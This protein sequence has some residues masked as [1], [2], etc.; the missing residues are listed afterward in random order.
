MSI[1]W[2]Q[3]LKQIW[4][5]EATLTR[6]GGEYD[7]NFLAETGTSNYI[8][9]VMRTGCEADFIDLQ[10]RAFEHIRRTTD[11]VPVPKIIKTD[12]GA[13]YVHADDD[14]GESRII[15]LMEKV[16]GT[17]YGDWKPHSA[18]LL[19]NIGNSVG[20]L[21]K[22][23]NS[24]NHPALQRDFK[25]NL[26][27]G[28]WIEEHI[29][30]IEG[31]N[32]RHLIANV[33]K[34]FRAIK[35]VLDILPDVAIHNDVND[36]NII[37]DGSL[38]DAAHVTGIIDLGD[39]C[40]APRVCDIAIAGAYMVLDH[41]DPEAALA[42]VVRGYHDAY[43][44]TAAEID[45]IW[46]LLRLRLAV[47][48]VNSTLMAIDNPDDPYVVIS[49]TPAWA[50]LEN[51][52]VNDELISARL[53]TA[54][55][56]PIT[57]KSPQIMAWLEKERGNFAQIMGQ[58]LSD[59]PMG[60]LSVENA[61]IPQNPFNMTSHEAAEIDAKGAVWLG[62]YAEPRLIYT[63][64]AFFKGAWKA[65]NRRT[66]HLGVD[67]F[68]PA[69]TPIHAPQDATVEFTDYRAGHLDYGG[70]VI[71]RH[72]TPAGHN[73]YTLYGHLDQASFSHLKIG[74]T[75]SKNDVFASL[76]DIT[77]NGGWAPHLHF[78]LALSTNGMG[79][80]WAG[81]ADPD[82]MYLW[83]AL[84]P[85]P[86]ALLN[87]PDSKTAYQQTVKSDILAARKVK[88]GDNL[89]LTYADPVM[90]LRGW[91]H[92]LF[93][94]WGRPYLDSYNNVPHV[95]HA[96]PRIAAVAVDQLKR[97]NANTRYLHPAQIA[98]AGKII[99]KLPDPLNVCFFVNSGSEANEL[100]LRL[101]RAHTGGK[102]M[103]TPN[104]GYHGNTTGAIDI[105]AY[106]FNAKGGIGQPDWVHLVDVADDYRGQFGREDPDR[107]QKYAALVDDAIG[108]I[109]NGGGKL[110]GFIAETFPSVGG[111]IIPPNGY[112]ADV[113]KHIRAAGGVCIAD[114]VQTGLGRLGQYYFGFEQQGALP[115]IV[116]L[117]K[118][119]GNGHPIG[120]VVT[121]RAIADS[122]ANEPEY[123][124]T[125]GGSNLSCRIGKEVLDIVDDENL[126]EN[127]RNM[128]DVLLNGLRAL[129]S[130]YDNVG[131]VRGYGLFI[132]VDLV[133]DS[134]SRSPATHIADYV[135]NRMRENRI[136]M[137]TE[138]PFDNILKI[139]PPLTIEADDIDMILRVLDQVLEEVTFL[140][141]S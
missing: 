33:V 71:L 49:Q 120:V 28:D 77:Q 102:D 118:P 24:F 140:N 23:F 106:K 7:L 4:G 62:Y 6:L 9:K 86:A 85:N 87:L 12:D 56:L 101:A 43:P 47:S 46:P 44:L 109:A 38:T 32:R 121:T 50:F 104:H 14:Q 131:D 52:L 18:A 141:G 10:C 72:E 130:I 78:Q 11:G 88:F 67:A 30:T 84:C 25:W 133:T 139:R 16:E 108:A 26:T 8:L 100:A 64:K 107:A 61:T 63:D 36:Y 127:A 35:P 41:P 90:F 134:I 20:L 96:H 128:G 3:V 66:V 105:S 91:K 55:N 115:D 37:V 114:E 75:L 135:K 73:F 136:L 51:A 57:D 59:V 21:D 116:V 34:E 53:R 45:L 117:G 132:G 5:I 97:M 29:D 124:S 95:G 119:I 17:V 76:G 122:F 40:S 93:D 83:G 138:G 2:I 110:A 92:H 48:V 74:Q 98:F 68:A 58:N 129:Q 27:Q 19:N 80:D 70:M 31:A 39:M 42:C 79:D 1:H 89:K 112:L 82:E 13:L 113:Y 137:G 81:V 126:M 99:S 94:E 22:A 15:W 125:F 60:S 103:I 54:C 65:S 123:F 111:Q 69:G